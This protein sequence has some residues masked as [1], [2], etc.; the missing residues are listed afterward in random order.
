M[1]Q[2]LLEKYQAAYRALD[3]FPLVEPEDIAQYRVDYGQRVLAQL[4]VKVNA[5]PKD[6]KFVFAGHRGCGKSTLLKR[7]SVEMQDQY[8]VVF[9]SISD[10]IEMSDVSHINILYAIGLMLLNAATK[11]HVNVSDDIKQSL[12]GWTTTVKKDKSAEGIKTEFGVGTDWFK[13]VTAK[14]QQDRLFRTELERTY[15]K[16]ITEFVGKIDRLAAAIQTTAKKPV[17]V[18]IDDLDKLDLSVVEP[19][20]R[21]NLKA[22]FSPAIK[23]VFTIP[24]AAAQEPKI[25]GALNSEG[26]VRPELFPVMKFFTLANGRNPNA[27]PIEA[28]VALFEQVIRKRFSDGV[29]SEAAARRM[30]L[31]SGGVMRELVR[32]GRECC[33]EAM[34]QLAERDTV[35]IDEAII[36]TAVRNLRNDFSRQITPAMSPLLKQVYDD[37][38]RVDN[39]SFTDLLHGLIILEYE[40]DDLWYD[41]HP[42]VVDLLKRKQVIT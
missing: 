33:T 5:A 4:K 39:E 40:N 23:I 9:F 10:L 29:L 12:L 32:L 41:L 25:M 30:V 38:G 24:I 6:G 7:F 3:L 22:L 31:L 26:I 27:D 37:R 36:D 2:A 11:A 21:K 28:N 20:Y 17:L 19:I 1:N 35:I 8:F 14:L 34:L 16:K 13:V 15:E 18:V 42:I